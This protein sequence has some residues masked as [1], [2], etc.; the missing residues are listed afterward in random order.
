M[1]LVVQPSYSQVQAVETGGELLVDWVIKPLIAFLIEK[2]LEPLYHALMDE[3]TS[4]SWD[5][6]PDVETSEIFK[7]IADLAK[8]Q[9]TYRASA[10][11]YKNLGGSVSKEEKAGAWN[12]LKADKAAYD[13]KWWKLEGRMADLDTRI[14][15]ANLY[16]HRQL[17]SLLPKHVYYRHY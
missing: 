7:D 13:S 8:A 9:D 10:E 17:S 11:N 5:K 12:Q 14:N 3:L 2:G 6:I 15:K 4:I 16:R 1:L